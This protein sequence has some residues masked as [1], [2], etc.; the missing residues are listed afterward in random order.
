MSLDIINVAVVGYGIVG[1][2]TVQTLIDNYEVIRR[3]TGISIK[4]KAIV[5]LYVDKFDDKYISQVETKSNSYKE[6]LLDSSISI[7]IELIGGVTIAKDIILEAI[8]AGKS[9]VTANKALLAINGRE[10]FEEARKSNVMIGYE[11]S[12][13]GGIPIIRVLKEDLVSNNI[14]DIYGIING[15][16]NYIL[17]RMSSEGKDFDEILGDAQAKG[18]AEA[19][20]TFDIDGI[21]TAHK[22]TI[23]SSIAF[24]KYIPYESVAVEGIRE[25]SFTDIQIIS[26]F[27]CTLKLLAIAKKVDNKVSISVR[28]TIVDNDNPLASVN[29]VFNA[30]MLD[31]DRVGKTLFYGRGAGGDATSSAVAGDVVAIAKAL[32]SGN[33]DSKTPLG[34]TEESDITIVSMDT[35]SSSF[36]LRFMVKDEI[37]VLAIITDILAKSGVSVYKALQ[38]DFSEDGKTV[39]LIFMTHEVEGNLLNKAIKEIG[40]LSIVVEKPVVIRMEI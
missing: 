18:Y 35:I 8:K 13:G 30:V 1:S 32:S 15:T 10:I 39:P 31:G 23:L 12:V 34:F 16:C 37:G 17:S 14:N 9:V 6:I 27:D 2:S 21:D 25:I 7:V 20:P 11:A 22:I 38:R 40:D 4:V 33:I 24:S 28:P 3:K 36:Y 29:G 19:N 26:E 5:D